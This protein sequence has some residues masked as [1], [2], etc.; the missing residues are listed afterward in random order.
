MMRAAFLVFLLVLGLEMI[1]D[2]ARGAA[3]GPWVF[4][5]WGLVVVA[6][7]NWRGIAEGLR[8]G[9]KLAFIVLVIAALAAFISGER[10]LWER[11]F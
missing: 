11:F 6:L 9:G 3:Q 8:R 4:V 5:G 7:Y 10:G 1:R 2:H